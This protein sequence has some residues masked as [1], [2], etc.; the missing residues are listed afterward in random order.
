MIIA[1]NRI[2]LEIQVSQGHLIILDHLFHLV[3]QGTIATLVVLVD[4]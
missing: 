2:I 4:L 1:K 3:D